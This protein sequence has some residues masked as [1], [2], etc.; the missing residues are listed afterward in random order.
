MS[1]N[2]VLW[3]ASP[4]QTRA[5]AMYRFMRKQGFDNYDEL[6]RWSIDNPPHSGNRFVSFAMC[7]LTRRQ[8][9]LWRGPDDIMDAGW[10][11]GSTLN[12]AAHLSRHDGI[13]RPSFS[14]VRTELD[15][16]SVSI[17]CVSPSPLLR[18]DCEN[19]EWL[20]AIAWRVPAELPRSHHCDA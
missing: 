15:G 7:G 19:A 18:P 13:A 10:F 11:S 20:T 16:K 9:R 4:E 17:S 6:Y 8:Q 12:F 2:R 1:T 14:V 5:T 3:Q